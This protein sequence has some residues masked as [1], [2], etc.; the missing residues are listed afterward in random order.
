MVYQ[1]TVFGSPLWDLYFRDASEAIA[2][3][4]FREIVYA[5]DLNAYR[6]LDAAVDDN[7]AFLMIGDCQRQLHRW[8]VANR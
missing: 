6:V 8:G 1:G 3:A 2:A 4:S 7:N 5:D